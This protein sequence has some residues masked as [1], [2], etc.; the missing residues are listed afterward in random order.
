MFLVDGGRLRLIIVDRMRFRGHW[1]VEISI[2][3]SAL[4]YLSVCVREGKR[5]GEGK[6]EEGVD[7]LKLL[8]NDTMAEFDLCQPST[9]FSQSVRSLAC[10]PVSLPSSYLP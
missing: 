5:K 9:S 8:T 10:L 1:K 3:I 7:R 4:V 6:R 2:G